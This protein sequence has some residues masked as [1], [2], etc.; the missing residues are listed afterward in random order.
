[1]NCE[2]AAKT[3]DVP[4][5]IGRCVTYKGRA[6]SITEDRGNYI[7]VTFDD[8]K[9]GTVSNFHPR[10]DNLIYIPLLKEGDK[11]L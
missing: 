4:A 3:Y 2:Y 5:C 6:G 10:T 9:P 11:I 8:E 7:G 1:M